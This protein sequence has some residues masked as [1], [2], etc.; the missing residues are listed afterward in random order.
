[1]KSFR[2]HAFSIS[3]NQPLSFATKIEDYSKTIS[4]FS[5]LFLVISFC[6]KRFEILELIENVEDFSEFGV[7]SDTKLVI[8]NVKRFAYGYYTIQIIGITLHG[9]MCIY[10][11]ADC[12][13]NNVKHNMRL[14]CGQLSYIW[15][16]FDFDYTPMKQILFLITIYACM[17][18][19]SNGSSCIA[20]MY[21][22]VTCIISRLNHLEELLVDAFRC[23]EVKSRFKYCVQ[24]HK[25]VIK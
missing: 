23:D 18:L 19:I 22:S 7:P 3:A 25:Y 13:K 2:T 6:I 20:L 17:C 16:P 11:I 8:R 1:M 10:Q 15:Y 4:I 24:Y 5:L 21:T 9:L 12:E 14:A